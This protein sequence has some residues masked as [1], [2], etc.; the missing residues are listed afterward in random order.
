MTEWNST[1][2]NRS[3]SPGSHRLVLTTIAPQNDD[4]LCFFTSQRRLN[5][6]GSDTLSA[7]TVPYGP[8]SL[9][10]FITQRINESLLMLYLNGVSRFCLACGPCHARIHP[11]SLA[12]AGPIPSLVF[13]VRKRTI[14]LFA[15]YTEPATHCNRS[16]TRR[17]HPQPSRN[18]QRC[19]TKMIIISNHSSRRLQCYSPIAKPVFEYSRPLWLRLLHFR[20]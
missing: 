17:M 12:T 16:R 15:F 5:H 18:P 9:C 20:V 3:K 8:V 11:L 2:S 14:M 19:K 1:T 13:S 6:E 4:C 10:L 7:G